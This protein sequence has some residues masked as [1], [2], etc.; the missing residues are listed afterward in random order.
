MNNELVMPEGLSKKER[1]KLK[2]EFYRE[3][4]DKQMRIEKLKKYG[5]ISVIC[6]LI[7]AGGYWFIKEATKPQPGQFV[8]DLGNRHLQ[9]ASD[10]HD[11]YNSLPPAS[12]PHLNEKAK[13][14]ISDTP[15]IDELQIH[16]LEDGGVMVQYNCTPNKDAQAD[17][18][19][20]AEQTDACKQLI[21]QLTDIVKKYSDKV[22]LAPYP[23]LDTKIALTAWTRIDKFNDFDRERIK[24]F[25]NAFRG[26]DHHRG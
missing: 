6:L 18:T 22:V 11:P 16:N 19:K 21:A 9:T 23:K 4:M 3:Q 10:A 12:G 26:I 24:K 13:W 20:S 7:L 2:R 25:I 14:G 8:A 1:K 17:A 15:I 5:I